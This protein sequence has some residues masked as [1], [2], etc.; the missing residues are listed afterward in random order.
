MSDE[1]GSGQVMIHP[2]TQEEKRRGE[3]A[4]LASRALVEQIRAR[5]DGQPLAESWPIIR[6]ARDER[7]AQL[8]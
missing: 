3:A 5:R 7:S 4:L 2:L 1:L 8:Q 6:D